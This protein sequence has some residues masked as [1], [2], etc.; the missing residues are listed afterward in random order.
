MEI[1]PGGLRAAESG[2]NGAMNSHN[3]EDRSD[4]GSPPS[5][6]EPDIDLEDDF[7]T[8]VDESE[9]AATEVDVLAPTETLAPSYSVDRDNSLVGFVETFNARDWEGVSDLLAEDVTSDFFQATSAE[10][11][12]E[13]MIDLMLRYPTL[14]VTRGDLGH[15]PVAAAWLL[16]QD[17]ER[18]GLVG[19]FRIEVDEGDE[20]LIANLEYIEEVPDTPDSVFE[21]PQGT[22]IDEWEDWNLAESGE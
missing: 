18:Y 1:H 6:D 8:E 20:P 4:A 2:Q 14:V 16:D 12:I 9:I 10:V 19:Y 17:L 7:M 3:P 21:P 5:H 15:D 11:L 22:E 13:G